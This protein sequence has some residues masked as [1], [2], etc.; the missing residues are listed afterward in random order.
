M[1][2]ARYSLWFG[3]WLPVIGGGCREVPP[4]PDV[5]AEIGAQ[6]VHFSE[7]QG[8][9]E[10]NAGDPEGDLEDRVSSALFDGFMEECLISRW[11]VDEGLVPASAGRRAGVDAVTAALA[12]V[13]VSSRHVASYYEENRDHYHRPE[14][15]HLQQILLGDRVVAE[16]VRAEWDAGIPFEEIVILYS[17]EGL[18]LGADE[19]DLA[20][21][22]LPLI[23]ADAIFDLQ[24]GKVSEIFAADY[25][26]HLFKVTDRLPPG[27]PAL[28]EIQDTVWLDL[29]RREVAEGLHTLVERARRRYNVR[30]FE[31][32]LPFEY[33]GEY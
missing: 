5:V 18:L 12:A 11:A 1:R 14:S 9:L 25:G 10:T 31:R 29:Q 26:F 28:E 30:V 24:P 13:E 19:G 17:Q 6:Q 16:E 3:L 7:F 33:A 27:V 22:E 15:V 8:Y 21:E 2:W 23:F 32:N 20:R 4:G